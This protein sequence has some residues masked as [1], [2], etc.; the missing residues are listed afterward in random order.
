[1]EEGPQKDCVSIGLFLYSVLL[2]VVVVAI[3]VVR[4]KKKKAR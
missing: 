3:M 4:A 2:T 1:M